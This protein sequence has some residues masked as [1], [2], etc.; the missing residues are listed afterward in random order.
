MASSEL[1]LTALPSMLVLLD[2]VSLK[3][4]SQDFLAKWTC[5]GIASLAKEDFARGSP[6]WWKQFLQE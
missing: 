2:Q 4:L 3:V 1:P 5:L 6:E